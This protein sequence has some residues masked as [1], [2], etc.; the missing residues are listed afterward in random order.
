MTDHT[1]PASDHA[2]TD[3]LGVEPDPCAG[4]DGDDCREAAAE[5][6]GY[7]DGALDDGKRALI[8]DHLDS[9]GSCFDA[10][11]FHAELRLVISRKCQT[12]LPE[13]LKARI[14]A[15]LAALMESDTDS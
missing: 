14:A 1:H 12:E 4:F 9:C 8:A 3:R 6:F 2:I 7:L 10:F 5:L 11:E 15:S 13:H